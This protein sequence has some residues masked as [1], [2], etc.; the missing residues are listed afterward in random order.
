MKA[1]LQESSQLHPTLISHPSATNVSRCCSLCAWIEDGHRTI[2]MEQPLQEDLRHLRTWSL[3]A[4]G[5]ATTA[6]SCRE[7]KNICSWRQTNKNV[8]VCVFVLF[9]SRVVHLTCWQMF[10]KWGFVFFKCCSD[11]VC[12]CRC[13]DSTVSLHCFYSNIIIFIASGSI[14]KAFDTG[15][16]ATKVWVVSSSSHLQ[17]VVWPV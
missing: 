10:V 4:V 1:I 6:H 5:I 17:A 11:D 7:E 12:V 3:Y 8:C 2:P 14:S 16:V 13:D 15:K 9:L